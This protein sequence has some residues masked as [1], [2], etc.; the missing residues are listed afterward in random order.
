MDWAT[1]PAYT[2]QAVQCRLLLKGKRPEGT[3]R[4][5]QAQDGRLSFFNGQN[6]FPMEVIDRREA[7]RLEDFLL[8]N[9]S[10]RASMI[11]LRSAGKE[12]T[13]ETEADAADAIGAA[14]DRLFS[15]H[16]VF[17][18][19]E[20][21]QTALP[22]VCGERVMKALRRMGL[23][24]RGQLEE[25][26]RWPTGDEG[27]TTLAYAKEE[28]FRAIWDAE[29]DDEAEESEE[30][31]EAK[32]VRRLTFF[33]QGFQISVE[34]CQSEARPGQQIWLAQKL[35]M[36]PRFLPCMRLLQVKTFT[37]TTERQ[38]ASAAVRNLLEQD[39]SY[40]ATW[41]QYA[42]MEGEILLTRLRRIGQMKYSIAQNLDE[43][44][45]RMAAV[46]EHLE[47]LDLLDVGDRLFAPVQEPP[48]MRVEK[49]DWEDYEAYVR[50]LRKNGVRGRF[51]I[52]RIDYQQG[53]LWLK[54]LGAG[55][56]ST[57]SC[58]YLDDYKYRMQIE[59]RVEA[60]QAIESGRSA[61][62]QLG[63]II[64]A[65]AETAGISLAPIGAA[66]RKRPVAR[67]KITPMSPGIE[68]DLRAAHRSLTPTQKEAIDL[69]LNTPDIAI[70]Q[71]PPGTGKTTVITTILK[72]L[73]EI[74]SKDEL[75]RGRVL[76]TS[77]QHDAVNNVINR[78]EINSLP[79][80]KFGTRY[81]AEDEGEVNEAVRHWCDDLT[82]RLL[83]RH[84]QIT[85]SAASHQLTEAYRLYA[86][87]PTVQ[88]AA[89]F[90]A[91]ARRVTVTKE[92]LERIHT[93]ENRYKPMTG[94]QD[95]DL[96]AA[97][98]R[99]WSSPRA[100]ADGGSARA[101]ELLALL[102]NVLEP[103]GVAD[104]DT[105][106]GFI[107][108]TLETAASWARLHGTEPIEDGL[109]R[110]LRRCRQL[111]LARCIPRPRYQVAELDDE[112]TL[113][114]ADIKQELEKPEGE[115][116][117]I[118]YTLLSQLEYN[119]EGIK[120]T[121]K[122][123]MFA[124]AATAQQSARKELREAK[125]VEPGNR[126][127]YDTVIVDE[128]ARVNPG[129]LL[130]PLSQAERRIILVGDH[131]QLPHMYDEEVFERLL[132]KGANFRHEDI[133]Q[134]MF[135]NLLGRARRLEQKDGIKRFITLD[136]QYRMHPLLGKFISDNF[137]ACHDSAEAFRSGLPAEHFAQPFT[138]EPLLWI[139]VP[140]RTPADREQ[141]L[142]PSWMRRRECEAIIRAL[143]DMMEKMPED[144][145]LSIGVISFY[146]GQVGCLKRM[147]KER[148][149]TEDQVRVGT[150]DAYQG[151]EYDI[152]FLSVVRATMEPHKID[153]R[154]VE[155]PKAK[156]HARIGRQHYGFL[157]SEN[158]LCVALSRQKRLLVV[159][160]N[161]AL[162]SGPYGSRLA[163]AY[164]P[165]LKEFYA[166]CEQKGAILHG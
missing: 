162:F 146:S 20:D 138:A 55:G 14:Q 81:G 50:S 28:D 48:Y 1:A 83:A 145:S 150:V 110:D 106:D 103:D 161:G 40:L 137:Y 90:L 57:G 4:I 18:V 31:Q 159:V 23:G 80:I 126:L 42:A 17:F 30:M 76:V 19:R 64:G 114:Y 85:E 39:D 52:E 21:I 32:P 59:R 70:I 66:A 125:E 141:R 47:N 51:E 98:R 60:Q 166:L 38:W 128:A 95:A 67:K 44:G 124:Y 69:A 89:A 104:A 41:R 92:L 139:D 24:G 10:N 36:N 9:F 148:G 151:M 108:A 134:S 122:D 16:I 135:E 109:R 120:E 160:G 91:V 115:A 143:S 93:L 79:I 75:A 163:A 102:D 45:C 7:R 49:L 43:A 119:Q 35:T 74:L 131:R 65:D 13:E 111:L 113:F 22:L 5:T 144:H 165:A 77:L 54:P 63:L 12:A 129:D 82:D 142:N 152:I 29:R 156:Q 155:D 96:L 164:V 86:L 2:M 15:L 27:Y 33:G 99:L 71:G 133:Q 61:N 140:V 112:I 116:D 154:A 107:R 157:T 62:P 121:L 117:N 25:K 73:N 8:R 58:L 118:L 136:V 127:R 11:D 88:N 158:R 101:A 97:I 37:V 153:W 34:V 84:P 3:G 53:M 94:A 72:R 100:F 56:A 130:I 123:Y 68:Q 78:V 26:L 105:E 87:K 132:E 147:I 46:E 6:V 149:W